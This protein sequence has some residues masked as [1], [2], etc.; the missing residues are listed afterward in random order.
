MALSDL[1]IIG[2][3]ITS[4]YYGRDSDYSYFTGCST[5][6]RQGLMLAQRYPDLYD[7]ILAGAPGINY[8]ELVSWISYPQLNES[9]YPGCMISLSA[10]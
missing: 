7:G 6:G 10:L 3:S 8:A 4:D 1:T 5:G 2:K 9:Y